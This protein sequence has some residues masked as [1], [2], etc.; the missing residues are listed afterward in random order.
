MQE[1]ANGQLTS[2]GPCMSNLNVAASCVLCCT[3]QLRNL[4]STRD[5]H[6]KLRGKLQF[7]KLLNIF[8][9]AMPQSTAA[10]LWAWPYQ[11]ILILFM[12][13]QFEGSSLACVQ[14]VGGHCGALTSS[15]GRGGSSM[16]ST[17]S[18]W[19]VCHLHCAGSQ[20]LGQ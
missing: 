4:Y 9:G 15:F 19:A 5:K 16:P 14:G 1:F 18:E 6:R 20:V 11:M 8:N 17:A 7:T 2:A 10:S 12:R 3:K 13:A